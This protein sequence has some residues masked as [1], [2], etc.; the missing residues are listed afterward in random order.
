MIAISVPAFGHTHPGDK[1]RFY[2]WILYIKENLE[3]DFKEPGQEVPSTLL[4]CAHVNVLAQVCA[5]LCSYSMCVV[6]RVL[7]LQ[8][9]FE[10]ICIA[11]YMAQK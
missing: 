5:Y 2:M 6:P 10:A 11:R 1:E 3:M 4:A 7:G 9:S 8:C